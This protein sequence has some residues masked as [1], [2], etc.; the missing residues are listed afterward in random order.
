MSQYSEVVTVLDVWDIGDGRMFAVWDRTELEPTAMYVPNGVPVYSDSLTPTDALHVIEW[1][2]RR[3]AQ[4]LLLTEWNEKLRYHL[5]EATA[6]LSW[7]DWLS[8]DADAKIQERIEAWEFPP[9]VRAVL[10]ARTD[11]D[12]RTTYP[13][14]PHTPETL[15]YLRRVLG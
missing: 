4:A 13:F 9:D 14:P 1:R 12:A 3:I 15:E 7:C 11:P 2:L 10:V 6:A 8:A 5:R